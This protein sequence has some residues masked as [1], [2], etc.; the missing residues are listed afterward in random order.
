M[1]AYYE[2]V[3]LEDEWIYSQL[4]SSTYIHLILKRKKKLV[5]S[6]YLF[7]AFTGNKGV[8]WEWVT[9]PGQI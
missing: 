4:E 5:H 2:V 1:H 6:A 8:K 7:W 3:H 9:N